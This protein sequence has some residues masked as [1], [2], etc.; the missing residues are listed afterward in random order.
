MRILHLIYDHSRNP[1]VGGGG[2]IRA[3]E[4]DRRL[5]SRGHSITMLCGSFPGASDYTEHGI[6]YRFIGA[7]SA[8]YT[9]STFSYAISAATHVLRHGSKYDVV[10]EDF[11]PWNPVFSRLLTRTPSVLHVNHCEGANILKRFSVLGLPFYLI[12]RNYPLMFKHV[13]ALSE[14]TRLKLR[15]PDAIVLPA[16]IDGAIIG[17]GARLKGSSPYPYIAYV[18]RLEL[19]NKGLDTLMQA[20]RALKG[21]RLVIAG[22]GRDEARIKELAEGLD[23]EFRGFVSETEKLD[24]LAGAALM[25]LPS[26]FEGW[27]IVVLEAAACGT[28]V[29]VSD[30]PEL[31][32]ATEGGYGMSF[33]TGNAS[34]LSSAIER[35]LLDDAMRAQMGRRA[36][37]EASSYTWDSIAIVC[38]SMLR[39]VASK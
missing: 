31:R 24:I 9:I 22:K 23:V 11:A 19:N 18:G 28:P 15:K 2:A 6:D 8:G 1:W 26:R 36:I 29:I 12:E 34:A 10:I 27:G 33:A 16:G 32:Y 4:V 35:M 3:V 14:G 38:E 37:D 39:E 30:I 20:M 17:H 25:V 13:S 7:S 5:A 21:V